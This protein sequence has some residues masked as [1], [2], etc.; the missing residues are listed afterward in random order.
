MLPRPTSHKAGRLNKGKKIRFLFLVLLCSRR[1]K[2]KYLCFFDR[3]S[4]KPKGQF[5]SW[6]SVTEHKTRHFST[7][8]KLLYRHQLETQPPYEYFPQICLEQYDAKQFIASHKEQMEWEVNVPLLT[9]LA[10]WYLY[11]NLLTTIM[12]EGINRMWTRW[13]SMTFDVTWRWRPL[14]LQF[15]ELGVR[16]WC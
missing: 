10:W 12:K 4:Q 3:F 14:E 2:H 16:F 7:Q 11:R 15:R 5:F 9:F 13:Q 8:H 1:K 6:H